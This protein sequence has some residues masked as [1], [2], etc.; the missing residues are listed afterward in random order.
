MFPAFVKE[1]KL[2]EQTTV[3]TSELEPASIDYSS[4]ADCT[5]VVIAVK[6][7]YLHAVTNTAAAAVAADLKL[8]VGCFELLSRLWW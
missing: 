3:A 5:V 7:S 4:F 6:D 2:A 8:F 1:L